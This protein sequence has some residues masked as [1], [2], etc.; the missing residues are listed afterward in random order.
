MYIYVHIHIYI[1]IYIFMQL[2]VYRTAR[3]SSVCTNNKNL[4]CVI[5]MP[6]HLGMPFIT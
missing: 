1:C 2:M 6:Q 5:G 3:Q 4:V